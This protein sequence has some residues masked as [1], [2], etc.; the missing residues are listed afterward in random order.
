MEFGAPNSTC[1]MWQGLPTKELRSI[2]NCENIVCIISDCIAIFTW[3]FLRAAAHPQHPVHCSK[4]PHITPVANDS[5]PPCHAITFVYARFPSAQDTLYH[6]TTTPHYISPYISIISSS[7][8]SSS[9]LSPSS[10]FTMAVSR[11]TGCLLSA[12]S[13]PGTFHSLTSTSFL[14]VAFLERV[15]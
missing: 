1:M 3:R 6:L 7:S 12:P 13:L 14:K 10:T 15:E 8:M 5:L 2:N 9:K 4:R 11:R